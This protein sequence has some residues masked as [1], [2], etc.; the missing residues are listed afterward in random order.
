MFY[1]GRYSFGAAQ[2]S[3]LLL[4]LVLSGIAVVMAFMQESPAYPMPLSYL[5]LINEGIALMAT[6]VYG[7]CAHFV[8]AF[9]DWFR[10][11]K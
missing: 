11:Q 9:F 7:V 10:K 5:L 2:L 3:M 1:I 6:L 8:V 4:F